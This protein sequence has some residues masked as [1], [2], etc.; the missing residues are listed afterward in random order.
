MKIIIDTNIALDVLFNRVEFFQESYEILKL[1]ALESIAGFITT[2]AVTDMYFVLNKNSKDALKSRN[3]VEQLV[4]LVNL[5]SIIPGD[6]MAAFAS[7]ITDFEDAVVSSAAKR[8]K[9]DYI[10]TRNEKDFTSS[11]VPAIAPIDFL[12]KFIR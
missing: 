7:N 3:A 4:K 9:A 6:I 2:N 11:P 12:D 5:E 10:V 8:I 1:T